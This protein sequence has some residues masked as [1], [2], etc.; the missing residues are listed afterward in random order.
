M[1]S[2]RRACAAIL[3]LLA[4]A[5]AP[6]ATAAPVRFG[7]PLHLD[8]TRAG[9]EP[10]LWTDVEHHT[11][12]YSSHAGTTHLYAPG[13]ASAGVLD[14]AATYRN[15]VFMWRSEDDGKTFARIDYGGGVTT[16][17]T[18]NSG[19]S[20]PDFTQDAGGR[21]YNTGINLANTALFSSPD[22]GKTWDAGTVQ[23]VPGDRPWLAG[24]RKDEVFLADN[25]LNS[26]G[27]PTHQVFQST[28]AGN[29]CPAEGIPAGGTT[30]AGEDWTGNGKILYDRATDTVVEPANFMGGSGGVTGVGIDTWTREDK[31]FK[32]SKAADSSMF[33]HW[34]AIAFDDAGTLYEVWD[35]APVSETENGGCDGAPSP[36]AN[37]IYMAYTKDLGKTWSK[38][39]TIA[40]PADHRVLWPW[41]AAGEA[42][43]V[44]VVWY[45]T[46]QVADIG[47][48]RV[49]LSIKAAT[50][51]NATSAK[52]R[53]SVVD[54]VG[55][56]IADSDLCLS[57]TTCVATGEDRRLGDFF[58][59]SVGLDGCV[60]IASGD[61]TTKDP[62]TG[63]ELPT[64]RPIFLHQT[65]G[66]RLR[67]AGDCSGKEDPGADLGLPSSRK[68]Q[69][70]RRFR[71]HL[72]EPRRAQLH[73]ARVYV[74]GRRVA[75]RR[76]HG[77]LVATINLRGKARGRYVVRI[78]ARTTDG[79]VVRSRRVYRTCAKRRA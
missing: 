55:R 77:R 52:R 2:V 63:G 29:S 64:S 75:V 59:N 28:D 70:R 39:V 1:P 6:V 16:D 18:K 73:S 74:D 69:S 25:V 41:V 35:D 78:V 8:A 56:P 19:F 62:V 58:T 32:P 24:G 9:G 4:A 3:L 57:G 23:C 50:L 43:R 72:R 46:D 30:E 44:S 22:G 26:N 60:D 37:H 48:V 20:D 36:L 13:L 40:A 42:G 7:K 71:I 49:K 66:P 65:S 11:I 5:A 12:L 68:C 54:A 47:C 79:R 21:I 34:P 67:G 17:P 10:V 33:A 15:Q 76:R 51:L 31:A 53:M 38:P 45:E 61:T 14:F 27:G